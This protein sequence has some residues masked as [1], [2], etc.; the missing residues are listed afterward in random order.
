M[1]ISQCFSGERVLVEH[2]KTSLKIN[3]QQTVKLRS[4][5][6]KFKNC[7]KHLA[8][9]FKS[10]VDFES[11]LKGVRGSDKKQHFIHWKISKTHSLQF[12]L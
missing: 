8:A 2:K 9:P 4:D 5:S 3:S 1:K 7:F 11:L 10:Y 12:C 6:I